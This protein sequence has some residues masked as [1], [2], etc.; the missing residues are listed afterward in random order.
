M[1]CS[2]LCLYTFTARSIDIRLR[3][4]LWQQIDT[5]PGLR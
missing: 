4:G 3:I 5:L 1:L 2:I